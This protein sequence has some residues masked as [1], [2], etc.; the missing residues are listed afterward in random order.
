MVASLGHPVIRHFLESG[1][2]M[3]LLDDDSIK[4]HSIHRLE[5]SQV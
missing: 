5:P 3:L 4:E 2:A 1:W